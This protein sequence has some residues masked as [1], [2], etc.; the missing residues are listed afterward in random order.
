MR[1]SRKSSNPYE[2][3]L[4][5]ER[6]MLEAT[7]TIHGL[8][9]EQGLNQ[10]AL[11]GRLGKSKSHVTQLLSGDRN[12]TLRTLAEVAFHLG[13]RVRLSVEPLP[14]PHVTIDEL[15]EENGITQA[16]VDAAPDD[17]D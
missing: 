17:K 4:E 1:L 9:S 2:L 5:S 13:V 8:L 3:T 15:M 14:E 6:L 11:A 10:A 12:L 16:E 7:E